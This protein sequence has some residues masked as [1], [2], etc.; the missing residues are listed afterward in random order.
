MTDKTLIYDF[1]EV[2]DIFN[3]NYKNYIFFDLK[4]QVGKHLI[5]Y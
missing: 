4:N 1:N 5:L 3:V 2:F